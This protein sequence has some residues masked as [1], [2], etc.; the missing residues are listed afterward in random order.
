MGKETAAFPKKR[1]EKERKRGRKGPKKERT[2][3]DAPSAEPHKCTGDQRIDAVVKLVAEVVRVGRFPLVL[4]NKA[5]DVLREEEVVV[6]DLPWRA[7]HIWE[8]RERERERECICVGG[9]HRGPRAEQSAP[10]ARPQREITK[11]RLI[12]S[13]HERGKKKKERG[14]ERERKDREMKKAGEREGKRERKRE[15]ARAREGE[16]H[17][18][19]GGGRE[20]KRAQHIP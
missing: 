20:R 18:G 2:C 8:E 13:A 15:S 16:R 14:R 19:R 6:V 17:G 3:C 4:A 5:P 10:T 9:G 1:E 7:N 11:P 12:E